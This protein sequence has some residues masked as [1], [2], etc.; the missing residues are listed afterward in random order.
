[1]RMGK[2]EDDDERID[3]LNR[4]FM[5]WYQGYLKEYLRKIREN[6]YVKE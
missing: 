1:M 3:K 5:S 2:E 4:E 6:G